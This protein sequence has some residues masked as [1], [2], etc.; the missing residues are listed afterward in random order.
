MRFRAGCY[1]FLGTHCR[2]DYFSP[3]VLVQW[4]VG[5]LAPGGA[6]AV[7]GDTHEKAVDGAAT[8]QLKL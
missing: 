4:A 3:P 7:R 6:G 5:I 8:F 2:P 1:I